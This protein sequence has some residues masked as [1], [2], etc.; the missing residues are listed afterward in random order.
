[1]DGLIVPFFAAYFLA[2]G[3]M[4]ALDALGLIGRR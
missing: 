2:L 1:M 4:L 3:A